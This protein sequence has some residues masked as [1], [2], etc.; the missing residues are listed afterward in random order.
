MND[1][2]I[3]NFIQK[4]KKERGFT[5]LVIYPCFVTNSLDLTFVE[6]VIHSNRCDFPGAFTTVKHFIKFLFEMKT[7]IQ[8]VLGSDYKVAVYN[9][10][11]FLDEWFYDKHAFE[12]RESDE[13]IELDHIEQSIVVKL[14]SRRCCSTTV[15]I[16]S[17]WESIYEGLF[18]EHGSILV[19]YKLFTVETFPEVPVNIHFCS[20]FYQYF[21]Q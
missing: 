3:K 21:L 19:S 6:S 4:C 13:M 17:M 10:L 7:P 16:Y 18:K 1:Q 8:K 5:L 12:L 2:T 15:K 20:N 14:T 9:S 11:N